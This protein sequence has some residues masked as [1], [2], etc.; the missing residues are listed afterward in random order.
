M[1][2]I[3]NWVLGSPNC[4]T[5]SEYFN[6]SSFYVFFASCENVMIGSKN[7]IGKKFG[8]R[9]WEPMKS[10]SFF[11]GWFKDYI[12]EKQSIKIV[13]YVLTLSGKE[14]FFTMITLV[15][16]PFAFRKV[17]V[18]MGSSVMICNSFYSIFTSTNIT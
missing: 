1:R 18:W 17:F 13:K 12:D 11:F 3:F 16:F 7:C 6:T 5:N 10:Q 15:L 2:S 14:F 4:F 9:D 8:I